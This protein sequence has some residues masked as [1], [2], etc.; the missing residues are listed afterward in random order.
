MAYTLGQAAR[1]CGRSKMTVARAIKAGRLSASRTENGTFA[2]DPAELSR[3]YPMIGN[4]AGTVRRDATGGETG[5]LAQVT[6]ERDRYRALAEERDATIRDLRARL[7]AE[8]D[9]RRRLV[10]VLTGPRG[11]WWRGWWP[12]MPG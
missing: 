7:D 2:I 3:V 1:A 9:E 11:A 4:G 10:A 12:R 6:G 5:S 8:A